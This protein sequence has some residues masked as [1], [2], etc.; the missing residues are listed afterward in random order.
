MKY[1]Y[2]P[3]CFRTGYDGRQCG[4]CH[5]IGKENTRPVLSP[6]V[7]LH[8]RY[9]IG[10]VLGTGGFGTT[11]LAYD[12][13]NHDRC[14]IKEYF[15]TEFSVRCKDGVSVESI[16]SSQDDVY[17]HGIDKFMEEAECLKQLRDVRSIVNVWDY[18]EE[19][20]TAYFVMDFLEGCTL[21]QRLKQNHGRIP[22]EEATEILCSLMGTL[23]YVHQ[24]GLIHRDISPE[25][26]FIT[27][28][29]QVILIDFGA[30]R[31]Y[32]EQQ[33][34]AEGGFSVLL[35][36]GFAP[37]EQYYSTG[38]QGT[39]T[40]V[41]ALAAT[42][43]YVV[44]GEK[45]P[46]SIERGRAGKKLVDLYKKNQQVPKEIS[47]IIKKAMEVD[48]QKRI[49]NMQIF[50]SNILKALGDTRTG[51][52][53]VAPPDGSGVTRRRPPI[54]QGMHIG[55]AYVS[56]IF[57]DGQ[58]QSWF[59]PPNRPMLMGRTQGQ[60]CDII[61]DSIDTDISRRHCY[62]TYLPEYGGFQICDTSS[63]G[64]YVPQGRLA[65][66]RQ[67]FCLPGTIFYLVNEKYKFVLEVE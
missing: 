59:L 26:I 51:D 29:N 18:F 52:V 16:S 3:N 4:F 20:G 46:Q 9:W 67:V 53:T 38:K 63:N 44:S 33:R 58:K 65:R 13:L 37:M 17:K 23:A 30:A 10:R 64:T 61:V 21:K 43:Y 48:Y 2:C 56:R 24:R 41:Y 12:D 45:P 19:N 6:V 11:Y 55:S 31:G 54:I 36:P 28:W 27:N 62:V 14:A 5:Y 7:R 40:D 42:Y 60:S 1:T 34:N 25:N 39:W 22:Y 8:D 35:K 15:P 57:P 32:L 47:Y 49:P 50:K 66:E